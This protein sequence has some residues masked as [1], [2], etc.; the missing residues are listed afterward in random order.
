MASNPPKTK[1]RSLMIGPPATAPYCSNWVGNLLQTAGDAG[2][3][4]QLGPPGVLLSASLKV[5]RAS[6]SPLRPNAYSEPCTWLVPD[7]MPTS[8]T[9]PSRHPYSASGFSCS[10]KAWMASTG[11]MVAASVK[12][13]ESF[14]VDLASYQL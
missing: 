12:G 2:S 13:L 5:L 9:A 10:L 1:S 11:R 14:A 8:I 3:R 7:L 4:R 6:Q